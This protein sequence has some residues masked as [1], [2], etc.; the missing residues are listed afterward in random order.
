MKGLE[1]AV[2]IKL[3]LGNGEPAKAWGKLKR[4]PELWDESGDTLIFFGRGHGDPSF[5]ICSNMIEETRSATLIAM[6]DK[7]KVHTEDSRED[8]SSGVQHKLC[9][10][11]HPGGSKLDV[12]RYHITTRNFFAFL[13]RKA[14]VGFTFYQALVDLHKRLE[15]YLSPGIDKAV[16]LQ[17]YLVMT[18]LLNVS[19][20]PRAAAGLLAWSEDVRWNNGWREAFAHSVGMYAELS[21]LQESAD[22]SIPTTAYLYRAHLELKARIHEAEDRLTTFYFDDAHFAQEEMPPTVRAASARFRTFLRQFYE[23]EYQTWP[24][25]RGQPGLWLDRIVV[26]R[27]QEDLNALYEYN[28]DR[29]VEW[30]DND[31]SEGRKTRAL[32]KSAN[33]LN[34]GLDGEDVRMLNVLQNLDCRLNACHVPHPYPLLPASVPGPPPVK[35]PVFGGKKKDKVRESRIAH[36]Y[37]DASNASKLS[38]EHAENDLVE[39]FVRFEKADQ[40]GDVDPREARRERWII[41][42]CVLQTLAGISVDVPNLSFDGDVSYFLNTRLQGLPPWGP[43]DN[44][45]M[46]ASREQS[47]CWTTSGELV[48]DHVERWASHKGSTWCA[49]SEV[50][51]RNRPLSAESQSDTCTSLDSN[52]D[53]T[54]TQFEAHEAYRK[55]DFS[56]VTEANLSP[57]PS[58]PPVYPS[59]SAKFAAVAGIDRYSTEPL[60]IRPNQGSKRDPEI[61]RPKQ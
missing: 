36:A 49:K 45:F 13:I 50:T 25:R 47:H 1:Q 30:R 55:D 42:Y 14:L 57:D 18:G 26:S 17:S 59:V 41:I 12:L 6:L 7:G 56:P 43:T 58:L 21:N 3:W 8:L 31:E 33:A 40:P 28:V 46:E 23:K 48:E 22:I 4:D 53:V 15:E 9:F 2:N 60:P 20:E 27:L 61:K 10:D 51:S 29:K 32:L 11:A 38:R 24:I 35:K 19:N 52:Q 44:I 37:A 5:R 34:F 54:H 16:A 39:A